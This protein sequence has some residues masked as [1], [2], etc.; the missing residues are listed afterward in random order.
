LTLGI[1]LGAALAW[2]IIVGIVAFVVAAY[3]YGGHE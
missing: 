1:S 2:S 3:L